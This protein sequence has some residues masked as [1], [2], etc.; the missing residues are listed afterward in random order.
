MYEYK[1]KLLRVVDG[2][3]FDAI[4]DLGFSVQITHRFR[5]VGIDTP[6]TWRP[7]SEAEKLHGEQCTDFVEDLMLGEKVILKSTKLGI[8][9]RYDADVTLPDGRNLTEVLIENGYE[10]LDQYKEEMVK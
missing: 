8:Y 3:T 2:D 7:K 10:K 5:L 6:E 4:V 1:A 9:G